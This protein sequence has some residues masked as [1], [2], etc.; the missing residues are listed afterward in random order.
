[1]KVEKKHPLAIRWFHWINFPVLAIMIWSGLLIY[2]AHDDYAIFGHKFFPPIFYDPVMP[3]WVP[4]WFPSSMFHGHRVWWTLD[5]RL[6]EGMSWHW[7]FMWLFC[8]NGLAYISYLVISGSW[9]HVFPKRTFVR[10]AIRAVLDDL[11]WAKVKHEHREYNGMQR[12]AYTSVMVMGVGSFLTGLAIYKPMK[13]YALDRFFGGYDYARIWHF[14][15]T[16]GF[17]GFFL[18]HIVQVVRAGWNNFRGMIT[19]SMLVKEDSDV[20]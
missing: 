12:L 18:V 2:W 17:V 15:L 6:A 5:A 1:M 10:D 3:S 9:R 8:F 4:S 19:G 14:V 7:L 11:P 20:A 13:V 16:I